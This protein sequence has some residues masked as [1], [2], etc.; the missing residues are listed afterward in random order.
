M[1][2]LR[3][4]MRS[5]FVSSL[6][7][8]FLLC[9]DISTLSFYNTRENVPSVAMASRDQGCCKWI[10][11]F[12]R[13]EFTACWKSLTHEFEKLQCSILLCNLLNY[14]TY[15]VN[16]GYVTTVL[17]ICYVTTVLWIQNVKITIYQ[18]QKR[19]V[20]TIPEVRTFT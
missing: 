10:D 7:F 3:V 18:E 16:G 20:K 5:I 19:E 13:P 9:C 4:F 12:F 1:K 6:C 8:L 2:A 11:V 14:I 15:K 17:W